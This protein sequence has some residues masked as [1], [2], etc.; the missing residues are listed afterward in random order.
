VEFLS[1]APCIARTPVPRSVGILA[2]TKLPSIGEAV[3]ALNSLSWRTLPVTE[4][5]VQVPVPF[6]CWIHAHRVESGALMTVWKTS[7]PQAV[8]TLVS[9]QSPA[10]IAC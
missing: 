10:G 9:A 6:A 8:A 4:Y 1:Y 2:A 5:H 3:D 7:Q